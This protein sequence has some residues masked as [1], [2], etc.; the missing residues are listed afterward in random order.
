MKINNCFSVYSFEEANSKDGSDVDLVDKQT[1]QD[2]SMTSYTLKTKV[3][4]VLT[5]CPEIGVFNSRRQH[6]AQRKVFFLHNRR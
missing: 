1:V 3:Q 2:H 4:N 6:N 5:I